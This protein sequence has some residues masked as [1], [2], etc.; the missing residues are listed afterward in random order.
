MKYLLST[1]TLLAWVLASCGIVPANVQDDTS[2]PVQV[3]STETST[4]A[5]SESSVEIV[6]GDEESYREF[7][8]QWIVP[9][10]PNLE[11]Q[12]VTVYIGST[13]DALPYDLPTPDG[14]RVI[15]SI[16]GSWVDY[17]LIFNSSLSPEAVQEFYAQAL[18]DK[19]WQETPASQGGGFT[20][21]NDVYTG[22]CYGEKEASLSVE[23]SR[24]PE[25]TSLRLNLDTSPDSYMCNAVP[26]AGPELINLI[27]PLRAPK[28]MTVQGSGA[29]SSDRDANISA[30]LRGKLSAAEIADVYNEQLVAAGWEMQGSGDGEGAAWSRWTFKDKEGTDWI[31]AL[32]IVETS[33]DGNGLYAVVTIEKSS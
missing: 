8:R 5:S 25:G 4:E 6:G 28:G 19:G 20:S 24:L 27:P 2:E 3:Q 21:S 33:T 32:M 30:S 9:V 17:V 29:G 23:T 7:I 18:I 14:T 11:P 12:D 15:G 13:P 10:G 26:E 22:Y 1:I 31:G 16:T